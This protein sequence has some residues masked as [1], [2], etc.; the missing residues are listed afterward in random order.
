[1]GRRVDFAL[2]GEKKRK[3]F[4]RFRLKLPVT[5][6]AAAAT[7]RRA[8][9]RLPFLHRTG[10]PDRRPNPGRTDRMVMDKVRGN[11]GGS[12]PGGDSP[13]ARETMSFHAINPQAAFIA[14]AGGFG[15]AGSFDPGFDWKAWS[16]PRRTR[17]SSLLL[18]SSF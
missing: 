3:E 1:M 4:L 6:R 11:K 14:G 10:P 7:V 13:F 16:I 2:I 8:L 18:G 15:P 12:L 5:E 9:S 17:G